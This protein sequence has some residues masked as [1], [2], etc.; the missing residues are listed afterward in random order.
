MIE[1]KCSMGLVKYSKKIFDGFV[2]IFEKTS[3]RNFE[4]SLLKGHCC[5]LKAFL[6]RY[7]SRVQAVHNNLLTQTVQQNILSQVLRCQICSIAARNYLVA[8]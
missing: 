1:G 4:Q 3:I 6:R 8:R 7:T 5:L 2:E